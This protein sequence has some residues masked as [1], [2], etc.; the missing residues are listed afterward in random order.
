MKMKRILSTVPMPVWWLSDKLEK[1]NR[2]KCGKNSA[3]AIDNIE[4]LHRLKERGVISE[5]DFNE[6]KEKIKERI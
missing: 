2:K 5:Q 4:R 1:R 3:D 6:L